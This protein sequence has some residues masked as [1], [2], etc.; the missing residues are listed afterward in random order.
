MITVM[1]YLDKYDYVVQL[2][3][4]AFIVENPDFGTYRRNHFIL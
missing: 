2:N 4:K 1:Y 3:W